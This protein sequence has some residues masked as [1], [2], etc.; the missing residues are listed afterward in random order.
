MLSSSNKKEIKNPDLFHLVLIYMTTCTYYVTN[1]TYHNKS[2]TTPLNHQN[3]TSLISKHRFYLILWFVLCTLYDVCLNKYLCITITHLTPGLGFLTSL[4][5][6]LLWHRALYL[7]PVHFLLE[8]PHAE[9]SHHN[10]S[11]RAV[12]LHLQHP[13]RMTSM[14]STKLHHGVNAMEVMFFN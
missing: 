14:V 12:A 4:K 6:A 7:G 8:T 9:Y 1:F 2:K 3:G 11:H 10:C 13:W 5:E